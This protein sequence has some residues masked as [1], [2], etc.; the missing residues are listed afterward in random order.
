MKSYTLLLSAFAAVCFISCQS[1]S[2][3]KFEK[4]EKMNWLIGSW[5][6]ALPEGI[7]TESWTKE[8][9]ST[10][11]GKSFFIKQKDTIHLE[12]IVLIQKNEELFYIPTVKGQNNDEPV[13]FKL[14]SDAEN[15]FT[16]ENPK[17]D[18]PQKIMYKKVAS[19]RLVAVI[20]GKQQGKDGQESYPMK[21]K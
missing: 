18:Y 13:T 20:S 10:Y 16:F 3:K 14:T 12:S 1:K 17:H 2:E 9:D 21:R 6:Q 8:N 19:D 5:E 4:L 7:L 15:A 11:S